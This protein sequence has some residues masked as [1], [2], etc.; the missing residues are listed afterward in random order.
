MAEQSFSVSVKVLE[1]Y[2][3]QVDFGDFGRIIT[4]EDAPLGTGEGPNPARMLA[5]AVVNCLTASLLFAIR[6]Y[7]G[8]PGEV[9]ATINGS[10]TRVDKR[11]RIEALDA[12]LHLDADPALLPELDKALAQ[13]ENFCTV[14]QSV[15][16]GI[17]VNVT[18][19]DKN[20]KVLHRDQQ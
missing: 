14:T 5:A 1:H 9:T 2:V 17:A 3:F 20:G 18:V 6:K 19:V 4:D 16:A 11:L 7:K 13:F 10:V 8:D 15:R 12:T